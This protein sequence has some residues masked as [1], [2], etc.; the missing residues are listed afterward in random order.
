MKLR[1]LFLVWCLGVLVW[2]VVSPDGFSHGWLHGI[3]WLP[4]LCA[5]WWGIW[6]FSY[7]WVTRKE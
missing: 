5:Y 6:N 7:E 4:A 2:N 3:C 1:R